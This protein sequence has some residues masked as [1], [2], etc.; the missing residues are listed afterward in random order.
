MPILNVGDL[1]LDFLKDNELKEVSKYERNNQ[2]ELDEVPDN[3]L[4]VL[5]GIC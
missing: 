3:L 5:S 2:I 4:K 1:D